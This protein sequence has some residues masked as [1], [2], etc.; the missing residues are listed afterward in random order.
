[1]ETLSTIRERLDQELLAVLLDVDD[2]II[3]SHGQNLNLA[4][5]EIL[6]EAGITDLYLFIPATTGYK[7]GDIFGYVQ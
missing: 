3:D 7:T 5:I 2:T 1:M 4:L 6:Q